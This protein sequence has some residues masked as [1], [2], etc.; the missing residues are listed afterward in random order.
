MAM[1]SPRP[2]TRNGSLSSIA[3][4]VIQP[5][6]IRSTLWPSVSRRAA[7]VGI[8][9]DPWQDGLGRLMLAKRADG[10]FAATV[11]GVVMSIPRQTGKTFTLGTMVF[12]L[13]TLV[14]G[15]TVLWTA[16]R[17]RTSDQTFGFFQGLA[18][19]RELARF[20]NVVHQPQG[21]Q[22]VLFRNGS[23]IMFGARESGFGRGFD[24]VDVIVFDEAQILSERAVAD[25]IPATNASPR[26]VGLVLYAG[27]PPKPT[28]PSE[29]FIDLRRQALN[30]ADDMVYVEFSADRDASPDDH[31]QWR[32]ANPS[33][34]S[35]TPESSILRMRRQLGEEDFRRE[36]LGVWDEMVTVG[37]VDM[38]LWEDCTVT[39][40]RDGGVMSFG[41]DMSPDRSS[42]AIGACMRYEDG[43]AHVELVRFENPRS[44]GVAWAADWLAE[45]W[46]R[47]AS[48]VIDNNSPAMV[49]I[50]E[51]RSRHVR[52]RV[53]NASEMGQACGRFQD[54]IAQG[55]LHHLPDDMQKPLEL[56]VRGSTTRAIGA[57]G[58][59]GW[60]KRGSDVD[61]SPLVAV[62]LALHG[63]FTSRRNPGRKARAIAI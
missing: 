41:V 57:S 29:V 56:A 21:R 40:R 23:R 61:I 19:R 31:R 43:S 22:E 47:T 12:I 33:Y 58:A 48:V 32:K 3:R 63:A 37:A 24:A 46:E 28:D 34:P 55:I 6:G 18:K 9:Y 8:E 1:A 45:R 44:R 5:S 52:P 15:M 14:P 4:H 62:T 7:Q 38:K 60:N 20:V 2:R 59:F 27:T 16:H 25:M 36:A 11:G 10:T 17:A 53:T 35:R 42:L 50:P 30:G 13:C 26:G 49:L 51:L 54:M 39:E